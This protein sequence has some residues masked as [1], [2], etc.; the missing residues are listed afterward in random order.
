MR[1]HV[2]S[3]FHIHIIIG[4]AAYQPYPN[5]GHMTISNGALKKLAQ[6]IMVEHKDKPIRINEVKI[7][8]FN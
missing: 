3:I 6:V 8:L 7:V 2:L 1:I 5:F 4:S